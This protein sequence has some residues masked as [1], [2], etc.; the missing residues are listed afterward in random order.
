MTSALS[1]LVPVLLCLL[2]VAPALG[3]FRDQSVDEY[4]VEV[5]ELFSTAVASAQCRA[6][7]KEITGDDPVD[8][9]GTQDIVLVTPDVWM[10][11][12]VGA[13]T[14]CD[15]GSAPRVAVNLF[16]IYATGAV[17]GANALIHELA[18]V[19]M[20]DRRVKGNKEERLACEAAEACVPIG[21]NCREQA[22]RI[23]YMPRKGVTAAGND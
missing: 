14:M 16:Y 1:R 5:S 11:Y 15:G 4:L 21:V 9:Y 2:I 7:F 6:R 20:C 10:F 18:H 22:K 12:G 3:E 8:L 19:A 17:I 23:P 13:I